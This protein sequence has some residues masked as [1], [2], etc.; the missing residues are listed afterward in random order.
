MLYDR[1]GFLALQKLGL[2]TVTQT[3]VDESVFHRTRVHPNFLITCNI[4]Y[5]RPQKLEIASRRSVSP[6]GT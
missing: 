3:S 4:L 2:E 6:D 5:Y 1:R